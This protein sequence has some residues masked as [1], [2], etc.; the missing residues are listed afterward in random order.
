MKFLVRS[1]ALIGFPELV[2]SYGQHPGDLLEAVGIPLAALQ[3]PELYLSYPA[4]ARLFALAAARCRAPVFGARLGSR[5]GLE[6]VGA[7]GPLLCLQTQV[8][9]ALTLI[10]RHVGFHARGVGIELTRNGHQVTLEMRLAFSNQL[11]CAQLMSLSMALL[12]RSIAQLH[13]TALRADWVDLSV[14]TPADLSGWRSA[15]GDLP[16][17]GQPACRVQYPE[18]LLALPIRV[19][20][21]LRQHLNAQWRGRTG[22]TAGPSLAQEVDRAI[23]ALLPTGDCCLEHVARLVDLQPRVLQLRLARESSSFGQLLRQARQ[24]LARQHLAHGETDLTTLALNLGFGDLAVFSRA[25][26]AWTG[27]SPRAWRRTQA[28]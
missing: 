1:G 8:G 14:P 24:R 18:S 5:Q 7:L 26:R 16:R 22:S 17:F 10:N 23:V 2:E 6:A 11:D 20:D 13:G 15:F 12:M 27:L 19:P 3:D 4:V 25:F 9:E 21:S 28:R